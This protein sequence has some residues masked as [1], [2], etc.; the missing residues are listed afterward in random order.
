MHDLGRS[1]SVTSRLRPGNASNLAVVGEKR[2][3]AATRM[4]PVYQVSNAD[5]SH[6]RTILSWLVGAALI[7]VVYAAAG[8]VVSSA[9]DEIGRQRPFDQPPLIQANAASPKEVP[10]DERAAGDALQA[11]VPGNAGSESN[12]DVAASQWPPRP[13]FKPIEVTTLGPPR[14]ILKPGGDDRIAGSPTRGIRPP[15]GTVQMTE[16]PWPEANEANGQW[17]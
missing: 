5:R 14:P 3:D 1:P 10:S 8:V 2:E 17:R 15:L 4:S 12:Q 16:L 6:G 9:Y 11:L 7:G 13:A